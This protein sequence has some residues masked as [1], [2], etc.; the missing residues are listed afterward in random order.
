MLTVADVAARS[1]LASNN[2]SWDAFVSARETDT[3]VLLFLA[4][5]QLLGIPRDRLP[6]GAQAELGGFLRAR[7][8]I[9]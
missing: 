6:P 7:G 1:A 3:D 2:L 4:K 9:R 5:N 8:L